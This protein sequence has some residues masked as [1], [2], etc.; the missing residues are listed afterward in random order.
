MVLVLA[1]ANTSAGAPPV[2][3]AASV[4]LPP[5]LKT[6]FVPGCCVWNSLPSAWNVSVSDAAANTVTVPDIFAADLLGDLVG[7]D[8]PDLD[9]D[10]PQAATVT[11]SANAATARNPN[12]M[13][14]PEI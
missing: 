9:D 6:T 1:A 13:N 10:E 14:T 8:E 3:L 2:M 11:T 4:S 7:D 12:L 5:K